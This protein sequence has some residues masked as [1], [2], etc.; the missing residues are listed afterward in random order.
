LVAHDLD[1]AVVDAA[2]EGAHEV[3]RENAVLDGIF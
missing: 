1:A 3:V 2:L